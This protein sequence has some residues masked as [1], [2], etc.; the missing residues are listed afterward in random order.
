MSSGAVAEPPDRDGRDQRA[1][2]PLYAE[3]RCMSN[4]SFLLGASWPS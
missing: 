1:G 4:F 3:L 2:I